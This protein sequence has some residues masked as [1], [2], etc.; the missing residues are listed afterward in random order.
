M[1]EP[2]S[3]LDAKLRQQTRL[4]LAWLHQRLSPTIVYVT[5]DQTEAMTLANR[6][7]VMN[8]GRIQQIGS[9]YD[10]YHFPANIFT[11]SFIGMPPINLVHGRIEGGRFTGLNENGNPAF[12]C[13]FPDRGGNNREELVMG[14]RPENIRLSQSGETLSGGEF[15][16]DTTVKSLELLG[17]EYY[18]SLDAGGC[19]LTG[20]I[21]AR[22]KLSLGQKLK[23]V[24]NAYKAHFF[25][26]KTGLRLETKTDGVNK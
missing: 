22:E 7:V 17:A 8:E 18:A 25:D 23:V 12:E 26:K 24:C 14:I 9:P 16:I 11:A 5:H 15:R 4:E 20:R 1:D 3:N 10:I 6:I 2:F 13:I 19:L 21:P